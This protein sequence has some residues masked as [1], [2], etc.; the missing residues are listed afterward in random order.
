MIQAAELRLNNILKCGDDYCRVNGIY[1]SHFTV[2]NSNNVQLNSAQY[3][4]S[5]IPLTPELLEQAGFSKQNKYWA[6]SWGVNGFHIILRDEYYKAFKIE[7][8]QGYFLVLKNL[9][10]LQNVWHD[11]TGEELT[12]TTPSR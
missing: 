4:L 10:H 9:H 6:K 5:E 3:N 12:L 11:H 2:Y 7:F 8:G 1:L